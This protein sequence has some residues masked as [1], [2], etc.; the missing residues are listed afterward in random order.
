MGYKGVLGLDGEADGKEDGAWAGG[1]VGPAS[2]GLCEC[3]SLH[4][5][6]DGN[7]THV[8]GYCRPP[9]RQATLPE[10]WILLFKIT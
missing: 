8:L 10:G 6:L 9:G 5:Y 1:R 7:L 3:P 4:G 2:A